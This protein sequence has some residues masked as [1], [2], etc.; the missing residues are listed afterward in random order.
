MSYRGPASVREPELRWPLILLAAAVTTLIVLLTAGALRL[1][2]TRPPARQAAEPRLEGA[3]RPEM[4]EFAPLR[5]RVVVERL[6]A[7]EAPRT[8]GE[9]AVELSGTVRN[10]TGRTL[11]GLEVRGAV[12]DADG[13]PLR[14]RTVVVVPLRQAALEPGEAINVRILLE[15]VSPGA[16]RAG[17]LMEVTGVRVD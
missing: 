10:D 16:V 17:V 11:K 7:A 6:T 12:L 13:S 8:L 4:P 15:G 5:E 9:P 2:Q 3:I 1:S 14:E